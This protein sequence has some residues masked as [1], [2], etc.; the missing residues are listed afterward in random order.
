[1]LEVQEERAAVA[2]H[3]SRKE[4]AKS[5]REDAPADR[6]SRTK[7]L[8][9]AT[10]S[11]L[12]P[13]SASLGSPSMHSSN[14]KVRNSPSENTQSS[15]KSKQEAMVRSPPVMSPSSAAQMDSKLPNQ[16]KQ[17]GTGGQSQPSPCDSKTLSGSHAPKGPQSTVGNL[18]LKNG[19]GLNSAS[20]AKGLN[21]ASGA[22]GLNSASGAKGLN[23]A[24]GA[25]GLNSA[26]GAKALNSA[27][28]AKGLNS[29]SGAKGKIKRERSTSVESFEQRDT[30]TP[31]NEP[32]Q[33]DSSR[34]KRMCVA[35]RRQPYSGADWCSGGESE[36]DDPRFFNCNSSDVK[37]QGSSSLPPSSAGIS[38]SS[39]PSHN[40]VSD[41]ATNQKPPS[42]IVY[43]FT[44]EMANKAAESVITGHAD[45]IIAFHMKN[46]SHC[47]ADK[48]HLPLTNQVGPQRNEPKPLQ[49]AA[50]PPEQN[51]QP[52]P[53]TLPLGPAQPQPLQHGAKL[54]LAQDGPAPGSPRNT[55]PEGTPG[56]ASPP[57]RVACP[58]GL[59][60]R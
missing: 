53:K 2:A 36:E 28:G 19:Q 10:P 50:T 12:T 39:T 48:R 46:I 20:G 56:L 21:S 17:G 31:S 26:S 7:A 37:S 1:M 57:W 16:G 51:H 5:E 58:R 14:P 49:Q 44:T 32:E 59:T 24:S 30:G 33:K 45:T 9:T 40:A 35:E 18:A 41:P 22:K 3:F 29:A 11:H 8:P 43:V 15:P 25:K 47:K 4:R 13:P 6:S 42:K 55:T 23:S 27:S 34:V 38:R 54:T 52:G 60:P